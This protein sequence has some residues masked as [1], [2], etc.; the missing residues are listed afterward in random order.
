M[1]AGDESASRTERTAR[2]R[3]QGRQQRAQ[4]GR[5]N[6]VD[7]KLS[8]EE[9]VQ[10][11]ARAISLGVSV[12]R[13]LVESVLYGG[14][15]TVT[16]R[17]QLYREL[18]QVRRLVA[19]LGNNVNQLARVANSTGYVESGTDAALEATS[20]ASNR[21]DNL[22]A[23]MTPPPDRSAPDEEESVS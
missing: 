19:A 20:R 10:V 3:S 5:R 13:L 21:L 16:E 12:P 11:Q 17:H 15:A 23:L 7:V 14:V 2:R 6:R 4:G 1:D 8:D 22:L 9:M 18:T